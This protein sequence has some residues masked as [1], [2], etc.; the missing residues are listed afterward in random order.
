MRFPETPT[1]VSLNRIYAA[2]GMAAKIKKT[3]QIGTERSVVRRG[4]FYGVHA[5]V[6]LRILKCIWPRRTL[7]VSTDEVQT[8]AGI[9]HAATP[10]NIE[11]T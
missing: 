5:Q 7:G 1:L 3:L 6:G 11:T 2:Y 8:S 4:V 9:N 10:V